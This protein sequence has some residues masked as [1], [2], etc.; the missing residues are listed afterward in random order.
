MPPG[1]MLLHVSW[2]ACGGRARC[3][4]PLP[5]NAVQ[6]VEGL[7]DTQI[8]WQSVPGSSQQLHAS[9]QVLPSAAGEARQVAAAESAAAPLAL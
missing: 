8:A 1:Q 4:R 3:C 7:Q 6:P 9:W 2:Q 5:C